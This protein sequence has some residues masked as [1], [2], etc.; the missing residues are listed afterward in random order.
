MSGLKLLYKGSVAQLVRAND[1]YSLGQRFKS[2]RCYHKQ[3]GSV[4]KWLKG[5]AWRVGRDV[6]IIRGGSNPLTSAKIIKFL[7]YF[8]QI[9]NINM[10]IVTDKIMTFFY[11]PKHQNPHQ[12]KN[13]YYLLSE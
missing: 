12:S 10:R 8:P 5:P 13:R 9:I 3:Q 2:S 7:L 1:S 4:P 6:N 11:A